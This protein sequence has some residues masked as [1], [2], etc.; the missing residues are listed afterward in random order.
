MIRWLHISD[1]HFNFDD[2]STTL[3][4]NGLPKFLKRNNIRCDYVFCTRDIRIG[5]T[6]VF[7]DTAAEYLK[8]LC[9]TVGADTSRLFIVPGNHDIDRNSPGRNEAIERVKFQRS[10]DYD[11]KTRSTQGICSGEIYRMGGK[12][13]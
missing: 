7:P 1:L 9:C 11:P 10:G 8:D 13:I 12:R 4:K 6:G 2:M 5:R 3:L